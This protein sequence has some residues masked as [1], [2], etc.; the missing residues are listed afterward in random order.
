[1]RSIIIR[2]NS[3]CHSEEL[4]WQSPSL[5]EIVN[6]SSISFYRLINAEDFPPTS[7]LHCVIA[8]SFV[9]MTIRIYAESRLQL[10]DAISHECSS[11]FF[12]SC[13]SPA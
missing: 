2:G 7:F 6:K 10:S 12:I 11:A 1:M 3:G 4:E 8:L 13:S 5:D 9:D